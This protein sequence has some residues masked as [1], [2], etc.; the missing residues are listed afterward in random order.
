MAELL[1]KAVD[2]A[3]PDPRKDLGCF[4]AGDIVVVRED[5]WGWGL[6]ESRPPADG[7]KFVL[8]KLPGVTVAQLTAF[9][10]RKW[11]DHPES[12]D[13]ESGR[14]RRAAFRLDS[15]P[16]PAREAVLGTGEHRAN[17]NAIRAFLRDKQTGTT[18]AGES[19]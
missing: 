4:K 12:P 15:L 16:A 18:A 7:G 6:E 1:I 10:A 9:W 2:A 17:W 3:L 11:G 8:V 13:R 19:L 14:I 5:G